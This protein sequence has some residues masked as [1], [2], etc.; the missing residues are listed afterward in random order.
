MELE[1]PD[2]TRGQIFVVNTSKKKGDRKTERASEKHGTLKKIIFEKR[3]G[4]EPDEKNLAA[5]CP[6]KIPRR[7]RNHGHKVTYFARGSISNT[8][9][10]ADSSRLGLLFQKRI[11]I[12]ADGRADE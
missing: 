2:G 3:E 11:P 6:I 12:A 9:T 10:H 1:K 7:V 5:R 4:E 8:R